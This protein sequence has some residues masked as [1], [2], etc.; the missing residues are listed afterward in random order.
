M[1]RGAGSATNAT[2]DPDDVDVPQHPGTIRSRVWRTAAALTITVLLAA[3]AATLWLRTHP[4]HL[5]TALN[6]RLPAGVAVQELRGLSAWAAGG[7]IGRLRLELAGTTVSIDDARWYWSIASV[8]PLRIVAGSLAITALEARLAPGSAAARDVAPLLP[9]FWTLGWW[10]ALAHSGATVERLRLLRDDGTGL[11]AGELAVADAGATGHASLRA[12]SGVAAQ[13]HWQPLADEARAWRIEW[14]ADAGGAAHGTLDLHANAGS[15]AIAWALQGKMPVIAAAPALSELELEATGSADLFAAMDPLLVARIGAAATLQTPLGAARTRCAGTLTAAQS[16]AAVITVDVCEARRD[17]AELALRMPLLL[18]VDAAWSARSLGTSGGSLRLTAL[19]VGGWVVRDARVESPAATL[20]QAG[21]T[22]LAT[23]AT[24]FA[25]DLAE[26]T[27]DVG[28]RLEG[29]SAAARFDLAQPRATLRASLH[30]SHRAERLQ[31]PLALQASLA[32]RDGT[33][34]VEGTL[35][36]AAIGRLLGWQLTYANSEATL[37]GELT[38]DTSGWHWGK[39]LLHTL[40]GERQT[41]FAGDLRAG[42]LRATARIDGTT[43]RPRVRLQGSA[44]GLGGTFGRAAF[45]GLECAPLSL[46]WRAARLTLRE[47]IICGARSVTAGITIDAPHATLRQT[48]AGWQLH[49]FGATLLGG[50]V[51]VAAIDVGTAGPLDITASVRGIDLAHIAALL[52]KPELELGGR[53]DGELPLR[54]ANGA[55]T[56]HGG[57]VR[58]AGPGV[59]RYRGA[60]APAQESVQLA[61]TRKALSNLEFDSLEATLDYGADGMLAVAAAIRG[62]NPDLDTKRPVHLNLTLET[63]LRTLMQSLSA[64]DRVNA[65]LEQRL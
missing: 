24:Q 63:N 33:L 32:A 38:L 16:L 9:R 12:P 28:L 39:G 23:P 62:R 14:Q 50:S 35:A 6:A 65:W 58:S 2:P 55:P 8:F 1:Q 45:I 19:P 57:T 61:L 27:H 42:T 46:A 13:L 47:E 34:A 37:G 59:I 52:A 30:A 4:Q 51:T 7:R 29:D 36:H 21:S 40:L 53:L 15:D 56:L 18:T 48:A 49:D 5:L 43:Q 26:P 31:Q 44:S 10:P 64:A 25:I 17:A 11:L 54:L 22:T 60:S 20:W 41:L 3:L